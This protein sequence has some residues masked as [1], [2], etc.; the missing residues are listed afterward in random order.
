[1]TKVINAN[2]F[3]F[4]KSVVDYE[5]IMQF[6]NIAASEKGLQAVVEREV[7]NHPMWDKFFSRVQ[8]CGPLMSAVCLALLD[9]YKANHASSFW[10][11][12]GVD[13]VPV[14]Q[15]DGT[16]KYEGRA[17]WH[18]EM[19][20]YVDRYNEVQ[21]KRSITYNPELKTKLL[22]VL[23]GSFLKAPNSYYGAIYYGYRSRMDNKEATADLSPIVKHRRATRYAIKCFL[24]DMWVAWR[25]LEG[26]PVSVPYEVEYLGKRPHHYDFVHDVGVSNASINVQATYKEPYVNVYYTDTATGEVVKGTPITDGSDVPMKLIKAEKG[27]KSDSKIGA[28]EL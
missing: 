17:K 18:T 12:A 4:I 1:M 3:N 27:S 23:G 9:P 25:E 10:K 15:E 5:L 6:G 26:L 19:R 8:G 22:G 28:M 7:K 11:Y 20:A 13:V 24:R 2:Q 14:P 21:T 16:I